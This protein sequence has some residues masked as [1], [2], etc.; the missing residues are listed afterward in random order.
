MTSTGVNYGSQGPDGPELCRGDKS[1]QAD[2][3]KPASASPLTGGARQTM[4]MTHEQFAPFDA[5][6]YL[7]DIDAAL[8][9]LEAVFEETGDDPAFVVQALG[10]IAR[11][12][13]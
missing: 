5:A 10:T 3:I 1:S 13:I 7:D 4:S 8:A 2:D 6:D 11:S 9:Y 12:G